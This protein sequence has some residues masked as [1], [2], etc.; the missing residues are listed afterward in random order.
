MLFNV[1]KTKK[2]VEMPTINQTKYVLEEKKIYAQDQSDDTDRLQ[3]YGYALEVL[4]HGGWMR[5][6]GYKVYSTAQVAAEAV[7]QMKYPTFSEYRIIPLYKLDVE[8]QRE[9]IIKKIFD[10][11]DESSN[12]NRK[13]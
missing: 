11:K 7:I 12:S 10:Y 9:Y 8:A 5:A 3:I 2:I 1:F 6:W 4:A 13:D